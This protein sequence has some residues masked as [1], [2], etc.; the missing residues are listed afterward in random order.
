M[1]ELNKL[2]NMDCLIGL[3]DIPD[4]IVDLV[5]TS[6]PYDHLRQYN[7]HSQFDF[8]SI[9]DELYRVMKPGGV[10]VWIVGDAMVKR[11]ETCSSFRQ[12]LYFRK[13]GFLL[14]DTMI[15]K[16]TSPFQHKVRYIQ[17]FEYMFIFSKGVPKTTN[18]IRDRKNSQAGRMVHGTERQPDGTLKPMS[19][20]AKKRLVREY[21]ARLNIWEITCDQSRETSHPAKFPVN[22]AA[23]HIVT[24]S[25]E[26]D[27][28]LDPMMGSGSTAIACIKT[29]RRYIGFEIDITYFEESEQRILSFLQK[30]EADNDQC[31]TV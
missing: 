17:A 19:G 26:N 31:R 9:A 30:M 2:Y 24:W 29:N 12:V 18:L 25:N 5:V 6:P 16:K 1:I 27:I 10:V 3:R 7:G 22:L 14:H 21:G 28:V 20:R 15:W 13:L 4:N 23:D 8:N 11:S